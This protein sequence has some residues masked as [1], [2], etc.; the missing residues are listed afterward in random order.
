M[1]LH[2]NNPLLKSQHPSMRGTAG[3]YHDDSSNFEEFHIS[4]PRLANNLAYLFNVSAGDYLTYILG[5]GECTRNEDALK[6]WVFDEL[7]KEL[8]GSGEVL[9]VLVERLKEQLTQEV[10]S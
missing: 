1:K 8:V 4:A 9:G 3:I 6:Y 10:S 7:N 5:H 2:A